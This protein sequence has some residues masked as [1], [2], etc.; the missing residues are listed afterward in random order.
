M[1]ILKKTAIAVSQ[2]LSSKEEA[3]ILAGKLLKDSGSVQEEYIDSMLEKLET[4]SFATYIGNGVAIPHGM[5]EGSK[6]VKN[7]GI[8]IIQVPSGVEWNEERA[9]IVV[10][11][12]A[13]SDDHM[14]VLASLADAIEDPNE[15][16]KLWSESSVDKI[17]DLL[18]ENL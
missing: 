11:I 1:E 10:G 17:F 2:E 3:T 14:N 7:T 18:S 9:Y 16:K 13:N 4:Q 12:A 15:A 8:S 6:Y 5:A